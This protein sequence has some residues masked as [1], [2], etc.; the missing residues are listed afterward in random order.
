MLGQGEKGREGEEMWVSGS[1]WDGVW[2]K[3]GGGRGCRVENVVGEG[4]RTREL[5]VCVCVCRVSSL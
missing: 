1:V 5:C 3:K 4:E 2:E